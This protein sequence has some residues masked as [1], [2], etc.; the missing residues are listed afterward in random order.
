MQQVN[1][2]KAHRDRVDADGRERVDVEAWHFE[3]LNSA[4]GQRMQRTLA[5]ANRMFWPDGSVELVLDLKKRRRE[6]PVLA[7]AVTNADRFVGGIGLGQRVMQRGRVAL[8]TV[9]AD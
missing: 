4:L 8:E 2:E 9:E 1:V 7:V 3:V 6:L 5:A